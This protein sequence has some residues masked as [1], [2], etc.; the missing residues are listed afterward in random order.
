LRGHVDPRSSW[1]LGRRA[2]HGAFY[3]ERQVVEEERGEDFLKHGKNPTKVQ[4][5]K[6]E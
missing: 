4:K 5:I 1:I 2:K 6:I 3:A